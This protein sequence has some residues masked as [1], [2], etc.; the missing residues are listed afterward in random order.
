LVRK[1]KKGPVLTLGLGKTKHSWEGEKEEG[2]FLFQG[3]EKMLPRG[4]RSPIPYIG[5]RVTRKER[6]VARDAKNKK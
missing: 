3:R 6:A 5:G 4:R 1:P 2:V